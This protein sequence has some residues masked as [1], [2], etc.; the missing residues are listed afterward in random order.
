MTGLRLIICSRKSHGPGRRQDRSN[1]IFALTSIS[2][3]A[4]SLCYLVGGGGFNETGHNYS[5]CEWALLKRF[6]MSEVKGQGRRDRLTYNGG[7]IH[8]AGV[9][10]RRDWV[11]YPL[12]SAFTSTGNCRSLVSYTKICSSDPES[13]SNRAW[14]VLLTLNVHLYGWISRILWPFLDLVVHRFLARRM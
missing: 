9:A 12:L 14:Q 3:D 13:P 5:S 4:I 10:W 8:L 2:H 6:S 11:G 7:G 1:R